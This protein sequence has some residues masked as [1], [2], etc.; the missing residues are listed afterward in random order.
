MAIDVSVTPPVTHIPFARSRVVPEA[1][2]AV[3]RVLTSGW[4]TTGPEVAAF[5][6]DFADYVGAPHAIAVASCTTAI[7]LSLR[8]LHLAPGSRVLTPTITFCGAVHAIVHAG[9][10]PVLVDVDPDTLIPT[11]ATTAAAAR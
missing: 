8:A 4:L 3:E 5:E 1:L 10:E 2:E 9:L 6:R 7:E 11:A